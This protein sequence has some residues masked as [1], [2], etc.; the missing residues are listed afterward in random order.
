MGIYSLGFL[1]LWI[2]HDT[3]GRAGR[4]VK[5]RDRNEGYLKILIIY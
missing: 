1:A 4:W 2:Q 5:E 3:V